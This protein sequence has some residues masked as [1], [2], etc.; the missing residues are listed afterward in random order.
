RSPVSERRDCGRAAS[1]ARRRAARAPARARLERLQAPGLGDALRSPRCRARRSGRGD[2]EGAPRARAPLPPRPS[3]E[4]ASRGR[5]RRPGGAVRPRPDRRTRRPE[6]GA[7]RHGDD[8]ARRQVHPGERRALVGAGGGLPARTERAGAR[9]GPQGSHAAGPRKPESA[10]CAREH[11]G[12]G[13]PVTNGLP[14]LFGTGLGLS[15]A[16]G[17]NSYAVLLVYGAM[18]RFFPEDY[19]GA[20][21]R[22]LASTPALG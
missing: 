4:V 20:I 22:L 13:E 19:P 16:A 12:E 17:L 7:A 11:H 14:Q 8:A 15:A 10:G 6:V 2:R 18:A 9:E 3:S 5:P 21:A 1:R